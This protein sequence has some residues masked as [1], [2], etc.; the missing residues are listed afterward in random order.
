MGLDEDLI[1]ARNE[2]AAA[3]DIRQRF[4]ILSARPDWPP[5][6][7]QATGYLPPEAKAEHDRFWREVHQR[8][9]EPERDGAAAPDGHE[10]AERVLFAGD[11]EVLAGVAV[12][13][14]AEEGV[15]DRHMAIED[16]RAAFAD[17]R[18]R[19]VMTMVRAG[20]PS[21][22]RRVSSLSSN[23]N[24]LNVFSSLLLSA[25]GNP[26]PSGTVERMQR[27]R[28]CL[29]ARVLVS[30]TCKRSLVCLHR[31]EGG[32]VG[33]RLIAA[34]SLFFSPAWVPPW[35]HRCRARRAVRIGI[36]VVR[37]ARVMGSSS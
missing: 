28:R 7:R 35:V 25:Y 8:A 3:A 6:Q 34:V 27:Q 31:Y 20:L 36:A 15:L 32:I 16:A 1:T 26:P 21:P 14:A 30:F 33:H 29:S 37:T 17:M 9:L 10:D 24:S 11:I 5:E 13:A 2:L 23:C 4:P 12:A 19:M 18:E 22:C